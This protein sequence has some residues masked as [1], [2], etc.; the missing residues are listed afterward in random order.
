MPLCLVLCCFSP[1]APH[2]CGE[3]ACHGALC[4]LPH[5][6]PAKGLKQHITTQL[7]VQHTADL[8]V[9]ILQAVRSDINKLA[10][11]VKAG[12][13]DA[14][15]ADASGLQDQFNAL[16]KAIPRLNGKK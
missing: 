16:R 9:K 6:R 8:T 1:F 4:L 13:S 2:L 11:D 3:Q 15:Q 10:V 7:V 12:D 14:I 5:D